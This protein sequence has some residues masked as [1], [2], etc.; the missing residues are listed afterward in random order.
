V[1]GQLTL[2]A[3]IN[4]SQRGFRGGG[5][6]NIAAQTA[7][8][9]GG[10]RALYSTN[11]GG[12]KGEGIA[13]T[14]A[15]TY[16]SLNNLLSAI[17]ATDGYTDGDVG[18]GAPGNAGGGGNQHN[19]GGGGVG[20]GGAGGN[21][22]G[23]WNANVDG[24]SGWQTGGY[25]GFPV[26][27]LFGAERMFLGG[28]GGA[29][30]VGGNGSTDPQGSGANGGGMILV[31]AGGIDGAGTFQANG[32]NAPNT[33]STDSAGGAGAGGSILV[34]VQSGGVGAITFQANG[35]VG[36]ST[37]MG[38]GNPEQDGPG[39]GGGGG[40]IYTPVGSVGSAALGNNG[41]L[42]TANSAPTDAPNYFARPGQTGTRPAVS[43]ALD[44]V[45]SRAGFECLP[46]L[47]VSK[48]AS[49]SVITSATGATT[50]YSIAVS[51]A[52]L[53]GGVTN[54]TLF[55]QTLP[56][57]WTLASAA[58]YTYNPLPS[59]TILGAGAEETAGVVG[60]LPD[61]TI[62]SLAITFPLATSTAP[63]VA[64]TAG[65][66]ALRW[67]SFF[68]DQGAS[69][70]ITFTV[71]IPNTATV[72]LYHNSAA[73]SY[74]DPTR[75]AGDPAQRRLVTTAAN[76]GASRNGTNASNNTTHASGPTTNVPGANYSGLPGGPA[77]DDV[78]LQ[79]DLSISKTVNTSTVGAGQTLNY[80]LTARNNGRTITDITFTANQANTA[81]NAN[82]ATQILAGS[83]VRVT[84]TL[85]SG[86]TVTT[87]FAGAG[88][89]C[90][91]TGQVLS[92]TRTPTIMPLVGS[93]S[94][95]AITGTV[96]VLTSAC[97]GPLVNTAT[98]GDVTNGFTD[99]NLSNNSSSVSASVS[100]AANLSIT[101]TNTVTSLVAG[102]TTSYDIT[103]TNTGPASADGAIARD[104]PSAGL[105]CT[106][107]NCT[108]NG[109]SPVAQCP[110]LVNW[111]NLL[112]G[113]GV[114]IPSLP[115]GGTV[116]FRLNCNVTA[117][118]VP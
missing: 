89:T 28:G 109:G 113:A 55:D 118:G 84:D 25:G 92:C 59:N 37:N 32:G 62:N 47:T 91:Q 54:L 4:V 71:N 40:V 74:V 61:Q 63:D 106:V 90:T 23:S 52:A 68:L 105:S 18:R 38:A 108:A 98:V 1:A 103:I 17:A 72:G 11:L 114:A 6:R 45:G 87:A 8:Q 33:G 112:T 80:T 53:S 77:S 19:A 115:S 39:G 34:T 2:N 100:C 24:Q 56:P 15:R 76:N 46:S 21:G 9:F 31:R 82:P 30:D 49:P 64:A 111:P 79:P 86:L 94:L 14:P 97:P 67:G 42:T 81:T 93:T 73:F 22:A 48:S 20:N 35:G 70:T 102:S 110:L 116:R 75:L 83:I 27:T 66:N 44:T 104:I 10:W 7:P 26:A 65:Q 57:G 43:N 29:G 101:K 107:S 96:R 69:M 117:T 3:G 99:S 50:S 12:M 85:P 95:P 78:R 51:N 41:T 13:G 88:W 36:G 5:V 16:D 58:T 60:A